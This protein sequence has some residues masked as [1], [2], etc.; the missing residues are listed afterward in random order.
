MLTVSAKDMETHSAQKGAGIFLC[1]KF[2]AKSGINFLVSR[3]IL[4]N[5]QIIF[6]TVYYI[7]VR[8]KTISISIKTAANR[9]LHI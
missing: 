9:N 8:Y 5:G 4:S 3:N 6:T 1:N 2:S 7:L